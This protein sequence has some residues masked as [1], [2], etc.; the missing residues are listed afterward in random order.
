MVIAMNAPLPPPDNDLFALARAAIRDLGFVTSAKQRIV[1]PN[2]VEQSWLID[3]R[4]ALLNAP[5]LEAIVQLAWKKLPESPFQLC[6]LETASIPLL[7]GLVLE[8]TRRGRPIS[9]FIV[10]RER[11][12]SGLGRDVEGV[13]TD[14]PIVAIDDITNSSDSLEKVRVVLE[15]HGRSIDRALVVVD[16]RASKSIAWRTRHNITVDSLFR[17]ED[18]GLNQGKAGTRPPPAYRYQPQWVSEA[19]DP[20]WFM[21]AP[22]SRPACDGNT[23]FVGTDGGELRAIDAR[24]GRLNW[25][26]QAKGAGRK[27]IWSSPAL[28]DGKVYFG[29]YNGALYCLSCET[30][31]QIWRADEADWIG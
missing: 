1:S 9:A 30:G 21:T 8:G 12:D 26:F 5:A 22:R 17:L 15:H 2:G 27:G 29:A 11:K 28:H 10:R 20:N 14:A 7:A 24:T 31:Q 18:F 23:L 19:R 16:F 6:G 13:I 4:P 25:S 3:L